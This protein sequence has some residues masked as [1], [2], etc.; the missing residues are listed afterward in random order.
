MADWLSTASDLLWR[1]AW[2]AAF[3]ALVAAGVCRWWPCR[4]ATR[5][6][7]WLGVLAW[8]VVGLLIPPLSVEQT[9]DQPGL[10]VVAAAA[11]PAPET[12][13]TPQAMPPV[14]LSVPTPSP[15]P[16]FVAPLAEP[17]EA[18]GS[19]MD[20]VGGFAAESSVTREPGG[21]ERV[22]AA[23][24]RQ[25]SEFENGDAGNR[26]LLDIL[27]RRG[28]RPLRSAGRG[29]LSSTRPDLAN[30]PLPPPVE[31]STPT[32]PWTVARTRRDRSPDPAIAEGSVERLSNLDADLRLQP[33]EASGPDYEAGKSAASPPMRGMGLLS[34]ESGPMHGPADSEGTSLASSSNDTPP[35]DE[36]SPA[37]HQAGKL[38]FRV[39][40]R[41]SAV[42]DSGPIAGQATTPPS[43]AAPVL[44]VAARWTAGLLGVRDAIGR[45]PAIPPY[46]WAL[47]VLVVGIVQVHRILRFR[48]WVRS[49]APATSSALRLVQEATDALGLRQAPR[50][51]MVRQR[52]SPMIWCGRQ[53]T[54]I[55]PRGL[56][57]ELDEMGRRAV[58]FHELAHLKRRD[59]WVSWLETIVGA[60][61]WWHPLIWWARSRLREE[62]ENCCDAWVMWLMPRHRR[63]Y[64]EALLKTKQYVNDAPT[65]RVPGP[66]MGVMTGRA[67][68]FA[69]RL[70]MVM[71]RDSGAPGLSGGGLLTLTVLL[72]GGW[73]AT[74]AESC[75][76]KKKKDAPLA[77]AICETKPAGEAVIIAVPSP[78]G[79]V[80]PEAITVVAP[81]APAVHGAPR[82]APFA[83]VFQTAAPA[84]PPETPSPPRAEARP[85]RQPEDLEGRVEQLERRLQEVAANLERMAE[86][87][88]KR[89]TE[90]GA[91]YEGMLK[92]LNQ[93]QT[94]G[95]LKKLKESGEKG[96]LEKLYG[97]LGVLQSGIGVG[98]ASAAVAG[99]IVVRR[100]ELPEGR[101]EALT[102][103][104][105][106]SDVPTRV[107]PVE[108][109][110]ELHGTERDHAVFSAF[111]S[112]IAGEAG[113]Q[114]VAY[115]LPK[116]K[117]EALNELMIRGDVP[118]RIS[119]G[120]DEIRVHGNSA[121]QAIFKAFVDMIEPSA[122]PRGGS[123]GGSAQ[124]AAAALEWH[125]LQDGAADEALARM[126][127]GE[128]QDRARMEL[129]KAE[130]MRRA[131]MPGEGSVRWT[132]RNHM[133][134]ELEALRAQAHEAEAHMQR[135]EDEADR[136]A[137]EADR[138]Q[139]ESE[140]LR[141]KADEL[142]DDAR[143]DELRHRARDLSLEAEA[144]MARA[145][146]LRRKAE[147]FE[148]QLDAHDSA[149]DRLEEKLEALAEEEAA[150]ADE[151]I[152]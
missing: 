43:P 91:A 123:G 96:D 88:E 98:Q 21:A 92:Q 101:R 105:V 115:K 141:E 127:H 41:S 110:I 67:K 42:Q 5:H 25:M 12:A 7:L 40:S 45:L 62:A 58:V 112:M 136:M 69:R 22:S 32:P 56:W 138:R 79:P 129:L 63:A 9:S 87:I 133:Q 4:P 55:L 150:E 152:R 90:A 134:A 27:G 33:G 47:G 85:R 109:G 111:V 35:A 74:P 97:A 125:K 83:A 53:A 132:I 100:Y 52:V 95:A 14:P 13:H 73:L 44:E 118:I 151:S 76:T 28:R 20:S 65:A 142:D 126:N 130:E 113:E 70:A 59:H 99:P 124:G 2:A 106:R 51:I 84:A 19:E 82:A 135:L 24:P 48:R 121:V 102:N 81:T 140:R 15:V 36:G 94:L 66:A 50:T 78:D 39:L 148:A 8:L 49:G 16:G 30:P 64:A 149:A 131:A 104:M 61:Y 128:A 122:A 80:A 144:L 38:R 18:A 1:N 71:T 31:E 93:A 137:D 3:L 139:D 119:P 143:S 117:L 6:S 107:K 114:V 77:A 103:L 145:D 60:I 34:A 57:S 46:V 72:I 10:V 68:R 23:V 11:G 120:E 147:E 54:L 37:S 17:I 89:T 146:D 86:R 108:G 116:A 29:P 75:D 26:L